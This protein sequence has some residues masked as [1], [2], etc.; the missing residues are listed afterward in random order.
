LLLSGGQLRLGLIASTNS[1]ALLIPSRCEPFLQR[2]HVLLKTGPFGQELV[3]FG[4]SATNLPDEL[5]LDRG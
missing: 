4:L 3:T 1:A 2:S 5:V